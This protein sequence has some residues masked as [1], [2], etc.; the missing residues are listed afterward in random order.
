[1]G[2]DAG[3]NIWV[4]GYSGNV[5]NYD[6]ATNTWTT[7]PTG[8]TSVRGI[9]VDREGIAWGA[10]SSPCG[11]V[12]VDVATKTLLNGNIPLPGCASPWGVSIDVDGYVWVVD[13]GASQAFKVD[14]VTH[15]VALTVTGLVGPYTYSD[16]TGAGLNLVVNP[17]G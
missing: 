8:G 16:M 13:M 10:G 4:G 5:H 6:F 9:M 14:P 11:L 1:M 7:I 15:Q 17:P 3:G 12:K 2:L